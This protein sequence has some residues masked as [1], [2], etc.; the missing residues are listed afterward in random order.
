MQRL[1]RNFARRAPGIAGSPWTFLTTLAATIAW[2]ASGAFFHWSGGWVLW[3]ATVTSVG[4]FLLVLLLQY[5]QNRDT[6]A[7][8]LKL[9]ELIRS[10]DQ[11]RTQLI[12]LERLSDEE[13]A[14]I[15]EE[16]QE[17]RTEQQDVAEQPRR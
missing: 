10:F 4:A 7:I 2:V 12:R 14:Q 9:D 11:A 8:Q 1:F 15:E 3:P 6:R 17:L 13:L 5:T 16:F